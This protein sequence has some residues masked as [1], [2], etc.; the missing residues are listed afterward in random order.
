MEA[1][2]L[3]SPLPLLLTPGRNWVQVPLMPLPLHGW[4]TQAGLQG[5]TPALLLP[6]RLQHSVAVGGQQFDAAFHY[7]PYLSHISATHPGTSKPPCSSAHP[8]SSLWSKQW[9][10]EVLGHKDPAQSPW[11]WVARETRCH[12]KISL[13][14]L[15]VWAWGD[16][17]RAGKVRSDEDPQLLPIPV[18]IQCP[19]WPPSPVF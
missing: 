4:W 1:E 9:A 2:L 10:G 15:L 12:L 18:S 17:A 6:P 13:W 8:F 14:Q 3:F 5:Q 11:W 19:A 16:K 7:W